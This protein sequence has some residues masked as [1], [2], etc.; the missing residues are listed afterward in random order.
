ME[1]PATYF[2]G[3]QAVTVNGQLSNN[4][5]VTSGVLLG[6]LLGSTLFLIYI[7]DVVAHLQAALSNKNYSQMTSS[8]TQHHHLPTP[9]PYKLLPTD[10]C[11]GVKMAIAISSS[12]M[13]PSLQTKNNWGLHPSNT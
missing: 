5:D 3:I 10:W 12:Q 7:N 4:G 1:F 13:P 8:S 9:L 6:S 11:Y 2:Y